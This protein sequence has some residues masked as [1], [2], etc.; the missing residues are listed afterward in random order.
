MDARLDA[1]ATRLW[2][3]QCAWLTFTG[4][5]SSI[6]GASIRFELKNG[7]SQ[8]R[9]INPANWLKEQSVYNKRFLHCWIVNLL[10]YAIALVFEKQLT[11]LVSWMSGYIPSI[12]MLNI[13]NQIEQFAARYF[14]LCTLVLP[15]M[16]VYLA[17]GQNPLERIR[18]GA[19]INKTP[20]WKTIF[21]LVLGLPFCLLILFVLYAAPIPMPETPR[22][23][24][25][26]VL[27]LMTNTHLGLLVLGSVLMIGILI[28]I[29][30]ALC[31][32]LLPFFYFFTFKG[33]SK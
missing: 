28:F 29:L 11:P 20:L 14:A 13:G 4:L 27:H 19:V 10:I 7:V 2:Q 17:W 21:F 8:G 23:S 31:I 18:A 16:T 12:Q 15:I 25:Q 5:E 22:L 33:N 9:P 26:H 30:A 32:I 24:G 3:G 6:E 1:A